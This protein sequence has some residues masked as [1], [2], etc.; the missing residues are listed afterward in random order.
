MNVYA[1]PF[2]APLTRPPATSAAATAAQPA[3]PST[4]ARPA[5]PARPVD[6]FEAAPA[7]GPLVTQWHR[8][9]NGKIF[10][11][12]SLP[13]PATPAKVRE[14]VLGDWSKWWQ[15][16]AVT[17]LQRRPDGGISFTFSPLVVAGAGPTKVH[18]QIAA[19]VAQKLPD[20][21]ERHTYAVELSGD[22]KGKA[23][24]EVEPSGQ[25]SVVKS[26]WDGV[27]PAGWQ[28]HVPDLS[29]AMHLRAEGG[30]LPL[31]RN[32]GFAGMAALLAGK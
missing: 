13:I 2:S 15:H 7:Q 17:N 3:R 8:V 29:A 11:E 9:E 23:R 27:E 26:I 25:G 14:L 21:R 32:T 22:F 28:K 4:T 18:V 1:R 31:L 16:S 30:K 10:C 12:T 19:P 6:T 24:I 20:G 5:G